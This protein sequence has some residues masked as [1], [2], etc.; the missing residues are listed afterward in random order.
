M[1]ETSG[2][3]EKAQVHTRQNERGP[4]LFDYCFKKY[5]FVSQTHDR[6]WTGKSVHY[7]GKQP[8]HH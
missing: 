3:E 2:E 5:T 8:V 6:A 4:K 1:G 7:T